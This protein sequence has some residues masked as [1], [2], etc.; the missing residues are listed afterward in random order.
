MSGIGGILGTV[1]GAS[2]EAGRVVTSSQRMD[3]IR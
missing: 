3:L 2:A 1:D